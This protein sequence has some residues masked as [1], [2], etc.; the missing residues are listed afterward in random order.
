MAVRTIKTTNFCRNLFSTDFCQKNEIFDFGSKLENLS[1]FRF[2][3]L[4]RKSVSDSGER[5]SC[6]M[7]GKSKWV[8]KLNTGGEES[9][10]DG[11][12]KKVLLQ[13]L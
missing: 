4:S 2:L 5:C 8:T 6:V 9:S 1:V 11:K 7:Q 10:H 3:L 13:G 12:K